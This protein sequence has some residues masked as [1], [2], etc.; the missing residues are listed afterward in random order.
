MGFL[1]ILDCKS[2]T[3][4]HDAKAKALLLSNGEYLLLLSSTSVIDVAEGA[5]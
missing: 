3:T 4:S 1:A 2:R 5:L